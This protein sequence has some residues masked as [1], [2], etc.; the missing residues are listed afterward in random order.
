MLRARSSIFFSRN[1]SGFGVECMS[2]RLEDF[3]DF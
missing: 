3:G 2:K 1:E